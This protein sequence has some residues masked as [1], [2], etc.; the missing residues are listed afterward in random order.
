MANEK[1][2]AVALEVV[3]ALHPIGYANFSSTPGTVAREQH[4]P[5]EAKA[6]KNALAIL[7]AYLR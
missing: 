6:Y 5:D 1:K 3:R 2:A 7:T 4:S